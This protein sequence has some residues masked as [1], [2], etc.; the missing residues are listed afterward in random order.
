VA[1]D[2]RK[3]RLLVAA[4]VYLLSVV[5]FAL[6]AGP[7]RMGSHTAF[8]H[9][10]H[11]AD[12]WLHGKNFIIRGG[13]GYAGGNDFADFQGKTYISFPPMPAVLMLPLVWLAGSPENFRDGQFIVWLAGLGPAVLFLVLEKLRR[14]GRAER[15]EWENVALS[16]AFGFGSVYF[17]TAVQGTVWFAAHVVGVGALACFLLFSLDA[18]RPV[19]AGIALSCAWTSRVLML[20]VGVFFVIEAIRVSCKN[21]ENIEGGLFARVETTLRRA[22][23]VVLGKLLLLFAAP[24]VVSFALASAY[25]NARFGDPSVGARLTAVRLGPLFVSLPGEEPGLRGDQPSLPCT[26]GRRPSRRTVPGERP[27]PCALVHHPALPAAV[28]A[29]EARWPAPHAL[30][31]RARLHRGQPA[32]PEHRLGAVR[33]PLLERLRAPLLRAHRAGRTSHAEALLRAARVGH[34]LERI[35]RRQ[36]R[37]PGLRQLLLQ[38][39]RHH[40]S[41]GLNT[42]HA[43]PRTF[44]IALLI[45][46]CHGCQKTGSASAPRV[47][48]GHTMESITVTS[49]AFGAGAR[50]PIDY[51][52]DGR[53]IIPDLTFS[54]P[55]PG[56]Q[57][58]V[59]VIDDPDAPSGV[60]THML[61]YNL[62]AEFHAVAEGADLATSGAR[63]GKNDFGNLRYNGPC[64]P[65]G[66]VHR[67]RFT[68]LAVDRPTDLRE[69][70][71]R[72]ELDT[73]LDGHLLAEGTLIGTFSH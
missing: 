40:L 69:G 13:P 21:Q 66:E 1:P 55:P 50:L 2:T 35:R 19:L 25:N 36:L 42:M 15:A 18:E 44:A 4:A 27:W 68:A 23:K 29:Q 14:T 54:A 6:V 49:H 20:T 65:K 34:R 26:Q 61:T 22:D 45:A 53:D 41:A 64:P 33:V 58:V 7:E 46:S 62:G 51:T 5:V 9:Y 43:V 8:N 12:A 38:R 48:P 57:S 71:T 32:L 11:L 60:F 47:A 73:E 72:P 70:L 24:L 28:V 56:T 3:R 10:A 30:G 17:F 67:Y 52:C 16:I 37:P 63:F 31:F 59:I 39:P